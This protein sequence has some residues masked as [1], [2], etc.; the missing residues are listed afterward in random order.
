MHLEPVPP[1]LQACFW[2]WLPPALEPDGVAEVPDDFAWL[3]PFE[4]LVFAKTSLP[5]KVNATEITTSDTAFDVAFMAVFL[6]SF[7]ITDTES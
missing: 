5:L 6:I 2:D 4:P 1:F 7:P 3:A